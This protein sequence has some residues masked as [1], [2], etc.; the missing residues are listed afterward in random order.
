MSVQP[1]EQ[2]TV[3]KVPLATL[4]CRL[5]AVFLFTQVVV[6][7][8]TCVMA[9]IA[10]IDSSSHHEGVD[11]VALAIAAAPTLILLVIVILLWKRRNRLVPAC[12]SKR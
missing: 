7:L 5:L 10:E 8:G 6:S 3:A 9:I 4:A 12:F 1:T 11:I 2:T